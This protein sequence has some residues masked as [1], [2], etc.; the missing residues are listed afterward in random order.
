VTATEGADLSAVPRLVRRL[1]RAVLEGIAA[2]LGA[3]TPLAGPSPRGAA[4]VAEAMRT[5]PRHRWIPG[6]WLAALAEE[7]LAT[8]D[9][10]GRFHGLRRFRRAELVRV[11]EIIDDSR[12][13]LGYPAQLTRFLLDTLRLLPE[14]LRDEVSPQALLFPGGD[15]DTATAAYRDNLI[16]RYLNAAAVEVATWA[17]R[18]RPAP[19]RVLE[20]GAGT[21]SLT[22]DLLPA[23]ADHPTD[24]LFTDISPFFLETARQRFAPHTAV[25]FALA[26]LNKDLFAQ[27]GATAGSVHLV[28]A[29]NAAHN[30]LDVW[31]LLGQ[32]R[33]LLAPDGVLMFVET[34]HEH[35]QSLTSMPFLLSAPPG[36]ARPDRTDIRAGTDRT[37]LTQEEWLTGFERAGLRPVLKLPGRADPLAAASQHL[38]VAIADR[39]RTTAGTTTRTTTTGRHR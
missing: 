6:R 27:S 32:I 20:L 35:H 19:L 9:P 30:A 16:N 15:L 23:L 22:T 26:D 5:A 3:A 12:R 25:R 21:G 13:G 10:D 7:G 14:L 38:F 34:C 11:R 4:E 18:T 24:Y 17:A 1:D 37:Y 33:E 31:R 28:V 39:A 2:G 36:A 8:R 29:A